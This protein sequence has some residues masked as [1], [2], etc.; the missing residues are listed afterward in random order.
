MKLLILGGTR[1]VGHHLVEAAL[2]RGHQVTLFN[3]GRHSAALSGV[4]GASG[5]TEATDT[6]VQTIVG[7][8][9]ADLDRLAGQSWDAVID[10]CGQLP[11]SVQAS[12]TALANSVRRYV[13]ISTVSVYADTSVLGATESAPLKQ[14]TEAQL[15]LIDGIDMGNPHASPHFGALYG[16]LKVL[17]EQAAMLAMP[18]RTLCLRPGLI[19]GSRDYTDRFAYWVQRVAQG[20]EVLAPGAPERSLQIIDAADLAA[21]TVNLL[22]RDVAGTF[23]ATGYFNMVGPPGQLTM[24]GF[25]DACQQVS[26]SDAKF[27]WVSDEFLEQNDVAPWSELPLWIP[28][29]MADMAGFMAF[30]DAATASAG[31]ASRPVQRTIAAVRAWQVSPSLAKPPKTSLN[32]AK[33]ARL[34]AQW[35]AQAQP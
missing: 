7:D 8:R 24:A 17:C 22:E 6:R 16:G 13:F 31:L 26:H 21:W 34:L 15:K 23:N 29:H 30:S 25:L 9:H 4:G 3:R 10:T 35:H 2:T 27:T 12:A 28:A 11:Q 32:A 20:G 19:V 18:G 5:A 1:F 14:L 33:E